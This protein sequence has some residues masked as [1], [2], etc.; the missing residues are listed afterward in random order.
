VSIEPADGFPLRA[1]SPP[2]FRFSLD[3]QARPKQ[4]VF[5]NHPGFPQRPR[6]RP[7]RSLERTI[8]FPLRSEPETW[9]P[10]PA[11]WRTLKGLVLAEG[12]LFWRLEGRLGR[13]GSVYG[14]ARGL[15]FDTGTITGLTVGPSHMTGDDTAI[16]PDGSVPAE[17]HWTDNTIGMAR[18][19]VD[20]STDPQV[21]LRNRRVTL[22]LG[23][24]GI[25][26]ATYTANR[27]EWLRVRRLAASSGGRL[28]WRVR[29]QDADRKLTCSSAV[30]SFIIDGGQWT[31]GE[32]DLSS[33]DPTA[34]WTRVGEGIEKYSL[35]F[36]V[37]ETF[38]PSPRY[39]LKVPARSITESSYMFKPAE[40]T[41]LGRL[42]ERNGV[43][44]LHWR[45]RG[46]D[47]QRAF[48]TYSDSAV[49]AS[50]GSL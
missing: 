1:D 17:F 6:R 29:A 14:P 13:R 34:Q 46:E 20:V 37:H 50:P 4:I 36:S 26:G 45:V 41:R 31:L 42:A 7:D 21:P 43:S 9:L 12:A 25:E 33:P 38:P 19:F 47:A 8:R 30:E 18:F 48:V 5:S 16:W 49:C 32:L 15:Y 2:E 22:T 23:R 27:F 39:T 24:R 10:S 40:V 3:A 28:Y 35:Q 44:S 11:Q